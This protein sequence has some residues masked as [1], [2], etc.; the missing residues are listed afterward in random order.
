[1]KKKKTC[2][3]IMGSTTEK[4][5][6]PYWEEKEV[7]KDLRKYKGINISINIIFFM[8][9]IFMSFYFF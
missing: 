8:Y 3:I 5:F 6:Y 9:D 4:S 7:R 2:Q 1:M